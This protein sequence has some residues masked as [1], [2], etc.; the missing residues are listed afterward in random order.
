MNRFQQLLE[1]DFKQASQLKESKEVTVKVK[2]P[3]SK[4]ENKGDLANVYAKRDTA[5]AE[6]LA[7]PMLKKKLKKF[8]IESV[9]F[10]KLTKTE[11]IFNVTAKGE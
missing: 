9:E 2:V 3:F 10:Y 6:K 5:A 8:E 7:K 11:A 1:D 4:Y